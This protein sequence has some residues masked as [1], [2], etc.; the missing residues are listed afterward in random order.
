MAAARSV[1]SRV[2]AQVKETASN[3]AESVS[4]AMPGSS[5][6]SS[7]APAPAPSSSGTPEPEPQST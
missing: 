4:N 1:I 7:E 3:V 2:V 5:S 6:S